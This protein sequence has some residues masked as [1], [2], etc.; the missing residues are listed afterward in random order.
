MKLLT[1]RFDALLSADQRSFVV[2]FPVTSAQVSG[3][4]CQKCVYKITVC[5]RFEIV[6]NP[7]KE[8][9]LAEVKA[10]H[11]DHRTSL[12]VTDMI[13]NLINL[14]GIPYGHLDGVRCSK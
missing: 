4:N 11:P 6:S 8:S 1:S 3:S 7:P 9:L 14:E 13:K 12:K 2:A 5:V 10:E